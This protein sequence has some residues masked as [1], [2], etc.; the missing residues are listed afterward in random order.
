MLLYA[1]SCRLIEVGEFACQEHLYGVNI[2]IRQAV[3]LKNLCGSDA[4]LLSCCCERALGV[5]D[6]VVD[7]AMHWQGAKRFDRNT[8]A[9]RFWY[10]TSELA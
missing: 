2:N 4:L 3:R 5:T 6:V 7:I 8:K 9:R 10:R 1:I